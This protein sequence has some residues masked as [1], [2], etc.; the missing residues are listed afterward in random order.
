MKC[1][2]CKNEVVFKTQLETAKHLIEN[3]VEPNKFEVCQYC[4]KVFS[5]TRHLK[6]HH[7]K[8]HP[9]IQKIHYH[10]R[11]NPTIKYYQKCENLSTDSLTLIKYHSKIEH[12]K[13]SKM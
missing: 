10:C 3:H 11:E 7:E 8:V 2:F 9:K 12:S 6:E 13:E 4:V 1:G 5:S